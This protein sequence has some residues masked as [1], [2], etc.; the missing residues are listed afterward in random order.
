MESTTCPK[1]ETDDARL[2]TL[3]QVAD[4]LQVSRRTVDRLISAGDLPCPL[5]V[6]RSS[7]LSVDEVKAY[8]E[9]L[10]LQ[11]RHS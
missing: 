8:L 6:G 9:S 5:K 10:K 7:R 2:L 11:R 1:P 4:L 3:D